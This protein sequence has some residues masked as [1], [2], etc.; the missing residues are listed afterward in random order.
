[1]SVSQ[2][3][4]RLN[5]VKSAYDVL[6]RFC[7]SFL[8]RKMLVASIQIKIGKTNL[9]IHAKKWQKRAQPLNLEY[10]QYPGLEEHEP[11]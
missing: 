11:G 8:C 4:A 3:N 7:F 6:L 9:F 1:M 5:L 2:H 10:F